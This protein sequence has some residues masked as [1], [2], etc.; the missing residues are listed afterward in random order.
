MEPQQRLQLVGEIGIP[1]FV[2]LVDDQD[3]RSRARRSAGWRSGSARSRAAPGRS[4]PHRHRLAAPAGGCRP[5][6]G[7]RSRR[8]T[9]P[10]APW[11][12]RNS[13][14]RPARPWASVSEGGPAKSSA[15]HHSR[16][17]VHG[18]GR[19]HRGQRDVE[20]PTLAGQQHPLGQQQRRLGLSGP[21][22]VLEDREHGTVAQRDRDGSFLH[23]T[24]REVEKPGR[25]RSRR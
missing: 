7:R 23:G 16:P 12:S 20:A 14:E 1:Q 24:K 18:V 8:R 3:L 9:S 5:A 19:R 15:N 17:A 25:A 13:A 10:S 22:L 2:N 4:S 6:R 11:T 21:G